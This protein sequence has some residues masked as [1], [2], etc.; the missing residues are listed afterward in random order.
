MRCFLSFLLQMYSL[1]LGFS[2]SFASSF[3][4]QVGC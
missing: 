2:Y 3:G 1:R 4:W